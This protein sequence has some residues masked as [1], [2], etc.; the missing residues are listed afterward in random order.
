MKNQLLD[1]PTI[2]LLTKI[3]AGKH[4][5]G[6][7]SAAALNSLVAAGLLLTV[8]DLT[9]SPKRNGRY[10]AVLLEFKEFERTI[11]DK[12]IPEL[13]S[14]F[15][16]DSN[17]FDKAIAKREERDQQSNQAL[18]ND[19]DNQSLAELKLS[20]EIPLRIT[21]LSI[22]LA[23]IAK[24]TLAKGF[25]SASGDSC[26]ALSSSLSGAIGSIGI[27]YLNLR[28]FPKS[29]W[30][31]DIMI[32]V[33]MLRKEYTY[34]TKVLTESTDKL[35]EEALAKNQFLNEIEKIKNVITN[36]EILTDVEIE[37][38]ATMVQNFLW[39][40]RARIWKS[41]TPINPIECLDS[42]KIFKLLR[43]SYFDNASLGI[44]HHSFELNEIAGVI[45][46]KNMEVRISSKFSPQIQN[47]TSAHELG[48]VLMHDDLVLHRD[49]PIDNTAARTFRNEKEY[50]ADRFATFF[51]MPEGLVREHFF[52]IFGT[53]TLQLNKNEVD[54]L[55][56]YT[57][58]YGNLRE[59]TRF[60]SDRLFDFS[61]TEISLAKYFGVSRE[62]MAIR[63]EE[64]DL[65][66]LIK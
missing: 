53:A 15:Q 54:Q 37:K 32:Q 50:Q 30:T 23:K 16:E 20:T 65:V 4:I 57:I 41:N 31:E 8:I 14:L 9:T 44:D 43:Y 35:Q 58:A 62:A 2:E 11:R 25:K 13:E 22:E 19:L 3:G 60:L 49:I 63:L 26:V 29:S 36:D 56:S 27:I 5:P 59:L 40:N 51:L 64:L 21:E 24:V 10:D 18:K 42:R 45:D 55:S 1:F 39:K 7:G 17:Q 12:I 66:A 46:K 28:S 34:F 33:D 6:S 61:R 48:H 38:R 52:R 47:F